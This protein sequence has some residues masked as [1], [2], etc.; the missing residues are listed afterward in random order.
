MSRAKRVAAR[1]AAAARRVC[2]HCGRS[3][4]ECWI[5]PCLELQA[6]FAKIE[7]GK[8]DS[9]APVNRWLRK[10]GAPFTIQP[11]SLSEV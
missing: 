11:K 5:M 2:P 7:P 10:T 1:K 9:A 8:P 3:G 6:L 4:R